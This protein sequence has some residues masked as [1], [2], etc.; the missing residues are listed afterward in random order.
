MRCCPSSAWFSGSDV[1]K[2]WLLLAAG[3]LA[4]ATTL[5]LQPKGLLLLLAF[6]VWLWIQQRKAS[7]S[8]LIW[9]TCGAFGAVAPMLGYFW[10]RGALGDLIYINVL[11]PYNNYAPAATVHY[12]FLISD[13]FT[14][15]VVPLHGTN[16]TLG[17]AAVLVIP[18][19]FIAAVP[20]VVIAL[21]LRHEIRNCGR[22]LFCTGS[23]ELPYG[24]R[25]FTVKISAT[26]SSGLPVDHPVRFLFA[27]TQEQGIQRGIQALSITSVC[28][29]AATFIIALVA[30]PDRPG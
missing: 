3:T 27:G 9:V 11:W 18:F 6:F 5:I 26:W 12:A 8:A 25:R 24:S 7:L 23:Q 14:H 22:R 29:A 15:W 30:R 28:L 16:W 10:S 21:G 1:R 13:Y 19:L 2:N 17:M 4:G 20:L